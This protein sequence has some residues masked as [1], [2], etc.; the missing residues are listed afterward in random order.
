[1]QMPPF[2]AQYNF[3]VVGSR[4]MAHL[5]VNWALL[6]IC[7]SP[8]SY[9]G[10]HCLFLLYVQSDGESQSH[11][12][13]C[14]TVPYEV[15]TV[16][17]P[18]YSLVSCCAAKCIQSYTDCSSQLF[19][20]RPLWQVLTTANQEHPTRHESFSHLAITIFHCCSHPYT[21]I[22]PASNRSVQETSFYLLPRISHPLTGAIVR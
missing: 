3:P 19:F 8:I 7:M 9:G 14:S 22:F 1:M 5:N 21:Y 12:S 11:N 2:K 10:I 16:C 6:H 18:L 4:N 13:L 15:T 20:L 17:V